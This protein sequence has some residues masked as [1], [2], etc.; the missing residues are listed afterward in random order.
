MLRNLMAEMTRKNLTNKD[1]ARTTGRDE[2]SISNKILCKTEF[3]RKEMVE[4]KK[5]HF[6]ECTMDYLFE[7]V[8]PT[9]ASAGR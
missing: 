2:K 6:P 1:L 9:V 7:Q 5:T 8:E 4:I 3:T